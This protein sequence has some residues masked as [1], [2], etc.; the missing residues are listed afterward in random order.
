MSTTTPTDPDVDRSPCTYCGRPMDAPEF[1]D[2]DG[3][4]YHHACR[5][6]MDRANAPDVDCL[7]VLWRAKVDESIATGARAACREALRLFEAYVV[8]KE[9]AARMVTA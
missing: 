2:E 7:Y 5:R 1:A 3:W 4:R 6:A 8:A 9:R